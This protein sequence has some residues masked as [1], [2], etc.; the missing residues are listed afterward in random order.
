MEVSRVQLARTGKAA[1]SASV[2]KAGGRE[3][4]EIQEGEGWTNTAGLMLPSIREYL[5]GGGRKKEIVVK[6]LQF[7]AHQNNHR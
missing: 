4:E 3:E 5:N 6:L 2:L 1:Q 7:N